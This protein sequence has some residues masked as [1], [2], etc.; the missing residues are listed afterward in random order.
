MPR[1]RERLA[2]ADERHDEQDLQGEGTMVDDLHHHVVEPEEAAGDEAEYGG[3]PDERYD[4]DGEADRDRGRDGLRGRA[5][6][7][8]RDERIAHL[9][10]QPVGDASHSGDLTREEHLAKVG[11]ALGFEEA[12]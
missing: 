1:P 8:F 4:R 7:E 2:Q 6:A 11:L 3:Q 12:E 9:A 10:A 5:L